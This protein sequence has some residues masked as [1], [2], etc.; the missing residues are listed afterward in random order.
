MRV[1]DLNPILVAV[2]AL[3]ISLGLPA[4]TGGILPAQSTSE[5]SDQE[6][7]LDAYIALLRTDL[8]TQK[9][10]VLSRVMQF[11]PEEASAFW[12]VYEAYIKELTQLGDEKLGVIKDYAAHY[13][14]L[15][16]SKTDELVGRVLD[17]EGKRTA[18][19]RKYYAKVKEALDAKAAAR[20]LQVEN[21]ILMLL[22]LKIAANLPV[23][24]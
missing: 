16:D 21:Q 22:D 15:S 9:V 18:L 12:P 3:T 7:N 17:L 8:N 13:A 20:F 11:T 10:N 19:K 5:A 23:V 6:Q 14:S 1:Q 4:W 24:Q 2:L